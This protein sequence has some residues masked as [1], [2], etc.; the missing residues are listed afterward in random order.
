MELR[1]AVAAVLVMASSLFAGP[2]R[3]CAGDCNGDG[4]VTVDEI[5]RAVAIALGSVPVESCLAADGNGD[6][7]ITVDEIV[8]GVNAALR[9]CATSSP[10]PGRSPTASATPSASPTPRPNRAPRLELPYWYRAYAG[11]EIAYAVRVVDPD[12]DQVHCTISDLP[13]AAQWSDEEKLF[14]WLPREADVG[15]YTL[16]VRCEDS[17]SPPLATEAVLGLTVDAVDSCSEPACDAAVGCSRLLASVAAPCCGAAQPPRS[18]PPPLPCPAGRELWVSEDIDAGFR[19]LQDCDLK[20]LQNN[21]QQSAQLRLKLGGRCFSL[22]DRIRVRVRLETATRGLNGTEPAVND[23]YLVRFSSAEDERVF[24]GPIA[25][26]IRGA[27]P[28]FDLQ[29]AEANLTV[30]V[31]DALNNTAAESLRLRLTFTPIPTPGP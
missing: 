6:V 16:P 17:G 7:E 2:A 27:R 29:D 19:V 23:E 10:T 1:I 12:G 26:S 30:Q 25:F 3:G 28:Y 18:L 13:H 31:R 24:S 9:G 15:T 20:Y 11:F 14:R 8:A 5:V 4:E 21:L 22:D